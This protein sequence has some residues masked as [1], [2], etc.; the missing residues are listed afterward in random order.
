MK[1]NGFFLS[2]LV[3]LLPAVGFSQLTSIDSSYLFIK[4]IHVTPVKNQYKSNTCWS[5]AAL[6]MIESEIQRMG[7]GTYDLSEMFVVRHSLINK[8]LKYVRLH[9]KLNF[10]GGGEFNDVMDVVRRYGIVPEE[11]YSGKNIGYDNHVHEEMQE[12]LKSYLDG[13]VRN[14]DDKL[15]PVWDEG[16]ELVINTYLGHVPAKFEYKGI[17][18]TPESFAKSTGINVDNYILLTSFTHHPYYSKFILELPDNWSW[19]SYYNLPLDELMKIVDHSINEGYTVAWA[20][21]ISENFYSWDDAHADFKFTSTDMNQIVQQRQVGFD[22][23]ETTDDHGMLICGIAK[24]KDGNEYY[25]MKN[26]WGTGNACNGFIYVSKSYFQYKTIAVM[27]NKEIL[28]K[29]IASKLGLR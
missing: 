29:D 18:Y 25:Y 12:V 4:K 16:Y 24:N 6:S 21:D 20:G 9:G 13:V 7:K 28:P 11:I 17:H 10:S 26:S 5:F 23:Y 3:F 8:G 27:V 14:R 15:S 1:T 2:I 19:E 22:N